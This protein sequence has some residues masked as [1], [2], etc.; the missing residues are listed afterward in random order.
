MPEAIRKVLEVKGEDNGIAGDE[1]L[2][3]DAARGLVTLDID[4]LSTALAET[5]DIA[6]T[7][8]ADYW[9][10]EASRLAAALARIAACSFRTDLEAIGIARR[11][12]RHEP[13]PEG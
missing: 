2:H 9:Q 7:L 3:F 6:A 11:A 13:D 1:W 12:L 8:L 4:A 5:V 10:G